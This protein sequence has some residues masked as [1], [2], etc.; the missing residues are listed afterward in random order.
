MLGL[1]F[2]LAVLFTILYPI[3]IAR[4]GFAYQGTILVPAQQGETT[5]YSGS[6]LGYPA[7]FTVQESEEGKTAEFL[8]GDTLYGPY[9]LT[10]APEAVPEDMDPFGNMQGI[11]VRCGEEILF[12]GG[13]M[14]LGQGRWLSSEDGSQE[15][16]DITVGITGGVILDEQGNEIDPMEPSVSALIDILTDPA[17]THKGEWV[18]WIAG[19]V[20]CCAEGI[21]ILFVD[22]LF[23]WKL[24]FHVRHTQD[25]EPSDWELVGRVIAWAAI[26]LM[27]LIVFLTGLQL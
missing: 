8:W 18:M 13:M 6:L 11:E 5:V 23:R 20:L 27:A 17:L 15:N 22:E 16:M 2:C 21:S 14:E 3:T 7:S 1:T 10:L 25:Q 19:M 26:P 4:V 24:S 12:R 9:T